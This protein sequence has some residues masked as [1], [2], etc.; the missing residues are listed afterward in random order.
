[1]VHS[2]DVQDPESSEEWMVQDV[3]DPESAEEWMVVAGRNAVPLEPE[4]GEAELVDPVRARTLPASPPV[5]VRNWARSRLPRRHVQVPALYRLFQ[6]QMAHRSWFHLVT[7]LL[8]NARANVVHRS[9][10]W[11]VADVETILRAWR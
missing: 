10:S 9:L 11:M 6:R 7:S 2:Q 8:V 5:P 3:Q 4:A 1:M